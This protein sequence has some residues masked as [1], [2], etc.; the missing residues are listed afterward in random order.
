MLRILKLYQ[1]PSA[2]GPRTAPGKDDGIQE[3]LQRQE[4]QMHVEGLRLHHRH[5]QEV[6]AHLQRLRVHVPISAQQ[7]GM[8]PV[9]CKG[10][11]PH[12]LRA[13]RVRAA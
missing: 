13:L 9:L 7:L 10:G 6:I 2:W 8:P 1:A 3:G 12:A 5:V 11:A 4:E